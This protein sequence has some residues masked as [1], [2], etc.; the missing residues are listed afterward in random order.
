VASRLRWKPAAQAAESARW[1]PRLAW[2][3]AAAAVC[4]LPGFFVGHWRG[5][6]EAAAN[7]L[8]QN[9]KFIRET[10][11]MF[12]NRVRAI[13]QD[14]RGL[15]LVLSDRDDVPVSAPLWIKVCDGKRCFDA[16]DVQRPGTRNCRTES[17]HPFGREGRRDCGGESLCMVERPA[18]RQGRRLEDRGQE[19][20]FDNP[21]I[22]LP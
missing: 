9:Q 13:V 17:H 4:L 12:P 2:G 6:T 18:G 8:L 22:K 15:S 20:E 1:F 10:L 3:L 14:E 11:A 5:Q 19:S 16:R 7:G 21:L